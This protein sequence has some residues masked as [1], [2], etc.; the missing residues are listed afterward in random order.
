MSKYY[1][2]EILFCGVLRRH[3]SQNIVAIIGALRLNRFLTSNATHN[4]G[5]PVVLTWG[6]CGTQG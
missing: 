1:R 2:G 3:V 6:S 4:L 5:I